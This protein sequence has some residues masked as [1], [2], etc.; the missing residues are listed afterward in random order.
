MKKLLALF[1]VLGLL[2]TAA[3]AY[4]DVVKVNVSGTGYFNAYLDEEGIDLE[5]GISD[6]SVSI[7]PS[8][9]SVTAPATITAE[10]SINV[11]GTTASLSKIA[12]TT[13]L[14]DLTYYVGAANVDNYIFYGVGGDYVEFTPKLGLEGISLTAY[15]ADIV[16]EVDLDNATNDTNNYFDDAVA[17]KLGVTNLDLLDA[18]LFGA[19]YDTDTNNATSAYGYAAH[20]NL[21]GKDILENLVVDLAYAYEATSM[22][23]VEA[24]YSKSF[25][26]EPVTLTVSPHFV[27]SEGAPKYYKTSDGVDWNKKYIKAGLKAEAGVTDELTFSAELTPTYDLA[28]NSFSLPVTLALAYAS[29]IA[30]ANVSASWGDAVAAA[31]DVTIDADLTVT[32]VENLTVKAAAQYKVATNELGYNVDTSYVYGP[33]TTGFFFGTLFNNAI[34]DYFT[35]YLY[36]KASVAF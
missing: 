13:D 11:L 5:G 21:T 31:T 26:M 34:H 27:Y 7:S 18:T 12:V 24:Q 3:F 9:G 29:D 15:F 32:A 6:L 10:F 28:A 30:S 2:V 36:L 17:L 23:L 35:W 14:F 22:Y 20:L 8:S 4:E 16:S 33:L 19:F 1:L 25:E